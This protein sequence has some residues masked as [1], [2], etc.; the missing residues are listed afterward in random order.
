V[1]YLQRSFQ[2]SFAMHALA[3]LLLIFMGDRFI[4][5]E[6]I[7]VVDF[8]L[9]DTTGADNA[10]NRASVKTQTQERNAQRKELKKMDVETAGPLAEVVPRA[11]PQVTLHSQES[12]TAEIQMP[13]AQSETTATSATGEQDSTGKGLTRV[14]GAP[15]AAGD[16]NPASV[17]V[18]DNSADAGRIEY[19]KANF[20]YIKDLINRHITYPKTARQMGWQGKVKI[21]FFISSDGHAKAIKI[22]E[23][24]GIGSLDLNAVE[25]VKSASPFPEPPV[26]AK[27]IIPVFYQLH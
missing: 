12:M 11:M 3:V 23:S 4:S 15:G 10:G 14:S 13:A 20:S 6:K 24:S 19:L 27:I 9:E 22:V 16:M 8:T 1:N 7:L 18:S 21:S 25:A 26:E 5:S 2:I 17:R